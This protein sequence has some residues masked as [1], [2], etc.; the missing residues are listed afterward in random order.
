MHVLIY[1]LVFNR[2]ILY[3]FAWEHASIIRDTSR[4]CEGDNYMY[5][6]GLWEAFVPT[7]G[8]RSFVGQGHPNLKWRH[9][10]LSE[11]N[12]RS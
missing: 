12:P 10:E 3:V 9:L 2:G 7:T 6:Y 5:V 1:V 11:K 4:C 8:T